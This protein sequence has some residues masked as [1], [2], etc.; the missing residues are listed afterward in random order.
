MCV[1]VRRSTTVLPGTS[2]G[3]F[4]AVGWKRQRSSDARTRTARA[5]RRRTIR[6]FVLLCAP[7]VAL[8]PWIVARAAGSMQVAAITVA[9]VIQV[10]I[11][12]A[13]T[14][15]LRAIDAQ[16]QQLDQER[17]GLREAFDR[18]RIDSLRDGLTG[19]G[20]HRAFQEELDEQIVVARESQRPFS[21][22]YLDLDNLKSTN[23]SHGHAAGDDLLKA[24]S[25]ILTANLRRGDRGFRIGGD[26]FAAVLVD[27]PADEAVTIGRRILAAALNAG[28]GT[29]G[30]EAFSMTIGVS[31]YPQLAADRQQLL[32]QADAAL[33]W[34]KRHGRTDVQLFDP[35]RHGMADDR[36]SLDELAA[37]VSL[38]AAGQRLMPVYQPLYS[39][40]TGEVLGYEG[41]VRPAPDSG[42]ANAGALFVAAEA[43]GH[44]VEL[45]L[46]SLETVLAGA[47]ALDSSRYLSVNLSPRSLEAEAFSPFEVLAI[48][49]RHG[50][51]PERIV[52]ELTERE[53]VE[54][55]ERLRAALAALR[56]HGVRIAADD[57]GAGNAG[58][59]LLTEIHF[60]ILKI[61]L[62][63]VRAGT[64][65]QSSDAILRALRDV[66]QRRGQTIVAEGVETPEQL[67][68]VMGL[69]FDSAQ[70]FLL[71]RPAPV[72][73][74]EALDLVRLSGGSGQAQGTSAAA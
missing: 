2:A 58:L 13:T 71:Q 57:V 3:G 18:A 8:A 40:R 39:L 66:A 51:D 34:G 15:G 5:I 59:R 11:V 60:D 48:A 72:M 73:N 26:E 4:S 33:Y 31:E 53:A 36:R 67:A 28:S 16:I 12:V 30:I 68:I 74:A 17:H 49:R 29:Y 23:D 20:N 6:W 56:R 70:G 69:G 42:F 46:A 9:I 1:A 37:A 44:T 54:D 21:L 52:V 10:T 7:S 62:S 22:L 25:R 35:S 55:M 41:L 50:V 14:I 47:H 32:H 61:D 64:A 45:D 65:S 27:C 38:V 63:L 24:A 43:T 19:L